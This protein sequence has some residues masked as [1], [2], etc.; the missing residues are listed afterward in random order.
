MHSLR[1]RIAAR[2][3]DEPAA[4]GNLCSTARAIELWGLDAFVWLGL[5]TF[6]ERPSQMRK[7]TDEEL[8]LASA[9]YPRLVSKAPTKTQRLRATGIGAGACQR[10]SIL[11]TFL[12]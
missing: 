12:V 1:S 5:E 11:L 4:F 3:R 10:F 9:R 8:Q 7:F 6:L 2:D